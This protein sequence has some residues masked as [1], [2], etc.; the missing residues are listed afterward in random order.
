MISLT[1]VYDAKEP[2][3]PRPITLENMVEFRSLE[4]MREVRVEQARFLSPRTLSKFQKREQSVESSSW[5]QGSHA[6]EQDCERLVFN[7]DPGKSMI[8][9]PR[10]P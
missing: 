5:S 4:H 3:V 1:P 10:T 2:K 9:D 8:E 7:F 6:P